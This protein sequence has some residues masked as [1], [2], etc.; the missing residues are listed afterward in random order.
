M[1]V[2]TS[3]GTYLKPRCGLTISDAFVESQK[4]SMNSNSTL[5]VELGA[6]DRSQPY[7]KL[8]GNLELNYQT[9]AGDR[10]LEIGVLD[11]F[12]AANGETIAVAEFAART[13][14]PFTNLADGGIL[15]LGKWRFKYSETAT[16]ITLRVISRGTMIR[17]L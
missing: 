6:R 7:L 14:N 13:G 3:E 2:N 15:D 17:V 16:N 5:R 4:L 9:T 8:R 1:T 12:A 10:N 11:S